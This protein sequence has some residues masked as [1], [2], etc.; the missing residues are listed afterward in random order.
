M[1]CQGLR[2]NI[3][4]QY[5]INKQKPITHFVIWCFILEW[6]L[7][8]R[9]SI[10][11]GAAAEAARNVLVVS[12]KAT[13]FTRFTINFLD[14]PLRHTLLGISCSLQDR[15]SLEARWSNTDC[16]SGRCAWCAQ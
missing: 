1:H 15:C 4:R 2:H 11:V 14:I 13:G 12:R 5:I 16:S 8:S 7:N 9:C 3:G 10:L 6:A